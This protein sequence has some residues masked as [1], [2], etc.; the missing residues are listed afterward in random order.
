MVQRRQC[1]EEVCRNVLKSS[2][3]S[4]L[5][6]KPEGYWSDP[7]SQRE[8]LDSVARE[9]NINA[10]ILLFRCGFGTNCS[11]SRQTGTIFLGKS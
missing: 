4:C 1:P 7:T 9:L 6:R 11:C 2:H 3:N 5:A 8:F 10:V